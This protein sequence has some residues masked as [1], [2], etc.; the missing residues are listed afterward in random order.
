MD[1]AAEMR[2]R[3]LAALLALVILAGCD[4]KQSEAI[5]AGKEHIAV[6]EAPAASPALAS[7]SPA[8]SPVEASE[9]APDEVA[10]D[11]VVMKKALRG[12]SRDP[13]ALSEEQWL[14]SVRTTDNGRTIRLHTDKGHYQKLR[15]GDRVRVSYRMGKYTGT[16]WSADFE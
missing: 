16:I 14:V 12:T 4:R 5:V 6:Q 15:R 1:S 11:S 9:L 13:R 2:L 8:P 10:V 3:G 7:E